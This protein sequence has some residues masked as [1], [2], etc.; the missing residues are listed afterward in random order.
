VLRQGA[1]V[2]LT[3][4]VRAFSRILFEFRDADGNLVADHTTDFA[5]AN[6]V[7][8]HEPEAFD[9]RRLPVGRVSVTATFARWEDNAL[10]SAEVAVLEVLPEFDPPPPEPE[11]VPAEQVVV[12][13]PLPCAEPAPES[14][15]EPEP[16]P[17]S[18]PE[19]VHDQI[20]TIEYQTA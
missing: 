10:V 19:P 7:V 1:I 14:A 4:V 20:P 18:P 6:C 15:P 12:L 3:G 11:P 5:R 17:E 8:H 9:I 16:V 2:H 13:E